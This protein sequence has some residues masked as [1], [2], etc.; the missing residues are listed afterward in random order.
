M[1]IARIKLYMYISVFTIVIQFRFPM[2]ASCKQKIDG[3]PFCSASRSQYSPAVCDQ[4]NNQTQT[5]L[6]AFNSHSCPTSYIVVS[7][8]WWWWRGGREGAL[9][10]AWASH[11][12]NISRLNLDGAKPTFLRSISQTQSSRWQI[13]PVKV[14]ELY[15]HV[16][17][18][19]L[20]LWKNVR[21][22]QQQRNAEAKV[23]QV[24][25]PS[26]L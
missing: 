17:S 7:W 8:G 22:H 16:I 11:D 26:R 3:F 21:V 1:Q 18:G 4:Q 14:N 20:W 24:R 5:F 25:S 9:N 13:V 6:A 2:I 15:I 10:G 23:L 19:L 12:N